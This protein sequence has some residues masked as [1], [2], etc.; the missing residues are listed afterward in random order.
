[1]A[2][3]RVLPVGDSAATVELGPDMDPRAVALAAALLAD[4]PAWL[5]DAVPTLGAVLVRV[6]PSVSWAEVED[7][8]LARAAAAPP[9]Q[10][11][12]GREVVLRARYD[13]ADLPEVA[14]ATGLTPDEV[15]ALHASVTYRVQMVG[16]LPG[17]AYLGPL[18]EAL[19]LPRRDTPRVRV[20]AGALAVA[21]AFSAVYPSESPGGW[22]LI[23]SVDAALFDP[24]REPPVLLAPGDTV[25]FEP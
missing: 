22:H 15:V 11:V 25:R 3:P 20:P 8:L 16:F 4:P 9:A 19:R 1:V 7:V 13:G 17:F 5:E 2:F 23:G 18:P 14:R 6:G 21:E 12:A 10:D 24:R